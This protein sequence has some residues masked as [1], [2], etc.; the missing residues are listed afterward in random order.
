MA[1]SAY[2]PLPAPIDG[3]VEPLPA[4]M[5][6]G[7]EPL[8]VPVD[9]GVEPLPAPVDGGVEPLP[10]PVDGG[11]EPTLAARWASSANGFQP[12]T[13]QG[14]GS[15]HAGMWVLSVV[16]RLL[17][18]VPSLRLVCASERFYRG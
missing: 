16:P 7:V 4:P 13:R 3:G 6:G 1:K 17:P 14:R 8:S 12:L 15:D 11:V 2:E 5:D 18:R 10:V 9:G